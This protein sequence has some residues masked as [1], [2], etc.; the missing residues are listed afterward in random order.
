MKKS[1]QELDAIDED[2]YKKAKRNPLADYILQT[3]TR[4][5]KLRKKI[6]DTSLDGDHRLH[7]ANVGDDEDISINHDYG[8]FNFCKL[9]YSAKNRDT[10]L[11]MGSNTQK[12]FLWISYNLEY[13]TEIIELNY[14]KPQ[15][16]EYGMS[17]NTFKKSIKELE[18]NNIIRRIGTNEKQ[19]DYWLFHINPQVIFVGDAKRYYEGVVEHHRDYLKR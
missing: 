14:N 9:I 12:L 3:K 19:D 17:L 16:A 13:K 18:S 1:P 5:G 7:F 11:A 10:V 2:T 8:N 6:R 15:N 4:P